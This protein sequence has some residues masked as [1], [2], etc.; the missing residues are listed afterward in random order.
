MAKKPLS[1]ISKGILEGL[2]DSESEIKEE[3][4]KRVNEQNN[5]RVNED[6]KK[7]RSFM[8]TEKQ[9][10]LLYELKYSIVDKDLSTIV[11][12]AIEMYYNNKKEMWGI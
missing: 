4:S 11:G 2:N 3:E 7:K 12:E 1:E 9:I 8:L 10:R 6:N 5:T